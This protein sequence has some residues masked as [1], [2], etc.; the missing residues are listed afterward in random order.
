MLHSEGSALVAKVLAKTSQN[1]KSSIAASDLTCVRSI[2]HFYGQLARSKVVSPA[3]LIQLMTQALDSADDSS[4]TFWLSA[5]LFTTLMSAD[6]FNTDP[7]FASLWAVLQSKTERR[8]F[9][10]LS[11][12]QAASLVRNR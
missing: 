6:E 4:V 11:W 2:L 3:P 12:T 1:L 9:S 10:V 8:R 5:A 7:A